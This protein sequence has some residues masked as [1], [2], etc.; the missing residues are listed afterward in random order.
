MILVWLPRALQDRDAQIEYLAERNPHA[1]IEQG[2]L[3]DETIAGLSNHPRM[4]RQGR[5][6]GTRELVIA[7]TPFIV[8]YRERSL[9]KRMEILRVL[10]GAQQWPP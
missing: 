6:R 7:G 10:H 8:V 5:V 2:D 9:A 4:G 1:A 3:L